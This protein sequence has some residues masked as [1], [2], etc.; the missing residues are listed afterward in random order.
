MLI[1]GFSPE[2]LTKN[3]KKK[4]ENFSGKN[5][6][7]RLEKKH[8]TGIAAILQKVR[9]LVLMLKVVLLLERLGDF[10]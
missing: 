2:E 7:S 4:P 10:R 8:K 3:L 9:R 1:F 5:C 6:Y